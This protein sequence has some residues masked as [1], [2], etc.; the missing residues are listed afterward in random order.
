MDKELLQ[1]TLDECKFNVFGISFAWRVFE[2]GDG[3]LMQLGGYITDNET[4][5]LGW[6]WGGK[7]YVSQYSEIDEVV[8]KAWGACQSFIIH[9]AREMFTYK[10]EAIFHP[11]WDVHALVKFSKETDPIKREDLRKVG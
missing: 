8:N 9:E 2:K 6:Q 5:E 3:F 11:H 7:Q 1:S 4:D 10:G